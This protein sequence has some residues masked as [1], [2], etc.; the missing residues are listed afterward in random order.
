M[1]VVA[2]ADNA[3]LSVSWLNYYRHNHDSLLPIPWERGAELNEAEL[4]AVASSIQ[5]FQLGESSEGKHLVRRAEEFARREGHS[6]YAE[7]VKLFVAEEHRHARGLGRVLDLAGVPRLRKAWADTVF[8]RLRHLA[9]LEMSIRVLITAE[10]IAKV[11]YAALGNATGSTVLRTLCEQITRRR[12]G[13]CSFPMRLPGHSSTR[14]REFAAPGGRV[15]AA[16]LV[17]GRLLGGL[18]EP[19]PSAATRWDESS[20]LPP[21]L[22]RR[23]SRGPPTYSVRSAAADSGDFARLPALG[24]L[25][26]KGPTGGP[27]TRPYREVA[28]PGPTNCITV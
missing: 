10:I 26:D 12:A 20:R 14:T 2:P 9:N 6:A 13:A 28:K 24:R 15:G 5:E 4:A 17:R 11:Y 16:V 23:A 1:P 27:T 21:A 22:P 7:A 25:S 18:E 8:R 3:L 19:S